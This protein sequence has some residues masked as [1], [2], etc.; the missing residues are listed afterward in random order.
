MRG[1]AEGRLAAVR[2]VG[3]KGGWVSW[4][5][6]PTFAAGVLATLAVAVLV[7]CRGRSRADSAVTDRMVRWWA[8]VWL[9]AA[10]ARMA[11]DDLEHLRS[12]GPCV[13]VSNHQSSLDPI[14][15]LRVLPLSL[16]ALAMR[17]LFRIPGGR[18]LGR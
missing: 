10:G 1:R 11:V 2:G 6:V 13:V 8:G 17:E 9:R 7:R 16:R 14:V 12:V 5:T 18:I 3:R 15:C 4:R